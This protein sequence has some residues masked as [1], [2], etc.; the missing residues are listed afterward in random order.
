LCQLAAEALAPL[1]RSRGLEVPANAGLYE[2]LYVDPLPPS[3]QIAAIDA[4]PAVIRIRP[5]SAGANLP[6]T[7][8]PEPG[9]AYLTFGSVA[10]FHDPGGANLR[11]VLAGTADVARKV[12]VTLGANGDPSQLGSVPSQ[13][14]IRLFVP[15]DEILPR[16]AATV[17]H[18]GAGTMM[19]ALAWGVPSLLLPMGA[20]HFDNAA[21]AVAGGA[22]LVLR[23]DELTRDAVADRVH[24]L[25]TD[26]TA[27]PG[28]GRIR[29]ELAAAAD[30]GMVIERIEVLAKTQVWA[31]A[32]IEARARKQ[33][34]L[35]LG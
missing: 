24:R 17:S 5:S 15:Q 20:D 30:A 29:S 25:L 11:V 21:R 1:W 6:F 35:L 13:V 14:D 31:L 33:R 22:A 8:S 27:T 16:C 26:P 10:D 7:N 34:R 12:I 28:V 19:G 9:V 4:L 3:M 32:I 18:A 23:P 2:H